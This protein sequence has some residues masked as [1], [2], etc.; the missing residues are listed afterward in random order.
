MLFFILLFVINNY[1]IINYFFI[2]NKFKFS[3]VSQP[4]TTKAMILASPSCTLPSNQELHGA[5]RQ[6]ENYVRR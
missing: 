2:N 1:Y 4:G 6:R 3:C 5:Q